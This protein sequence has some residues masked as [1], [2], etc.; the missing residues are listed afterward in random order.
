VCSETCPEASYW[1]PDEGVGDFFVMTE[2]VPGQ[3][4]SEYHGSSLYWK[5]DGKWVANKLPAIEKVLDLLPAAAM[6]HCLK[7]LAIPAAVAGKT[8]AA[9]RLCC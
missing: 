7:R 6:L 5:A 3:I 8:R 1:P 2:W 4:G 9:I